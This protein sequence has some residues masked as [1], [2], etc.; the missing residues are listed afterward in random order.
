MSIEPRTVHL[1]VLVTKSLEIDEPDWC[2]DAH[3]GAQF[4]P[5][6]THN[7]PEISAHVETR[8]GTA[9]YLTA[10]ITQAPYGELRPEPLPI[11]AIDIDGD[12]LSLDPDG[13]RT[14]T[15]A[16]RAHLDALDR[17]ADECDRIRDGGEA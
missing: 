14:F 9:T 17:L 15:A 7:G 2:I 13:V 16:T 1:S 12:V 6:I 10:W 5:D 3:T 4:L 11:V 8:H